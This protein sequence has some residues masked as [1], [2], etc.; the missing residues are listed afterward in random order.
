MSVQTITAPNGDRLVVLP[1]A[2]YLAMQEALEDAA[3]IAAV[4]AY[5]R[6]KA[7]GEAVMIP[8]AFVDRILDGESKVRVFREFRGLSARDLA[9]KAEISPSYLSQIESG[10]RDGSFDTMKRIAAALG[11]S[12]DDLA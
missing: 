2:D 11:I 3:D 8:A 12:V 6:Q 5:E 7:A 9:G 4:D 1:E 10:A